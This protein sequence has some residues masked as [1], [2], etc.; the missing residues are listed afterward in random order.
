M[1]K[2]LH[3]D[4][5]LW[6]QEIP[7]G[8]ILRSASL[9]TVHAISA[10]IRIS[11][12]RSITSGLR[13]RIGVCT[14]EEVLAAPIGYGWRETGAADFDYRVVAADNGR[15]DSPLFALPLGI[16]ATHCGASQLVS[17]KAPVMST[18]HTTPSPD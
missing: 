4:V 11:R 9:Q 17:R 12:V 10:V 13:T 8:T 5:A 18:G 2:S 14:G 15:L 3:G 1:Q 7:R 16:A 6:R